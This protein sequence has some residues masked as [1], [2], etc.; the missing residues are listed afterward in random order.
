MITPI[1]LTKKLEK[2]LSK[3]ITITTPLLGNNFGKWNMTIFYIA[4]KKWLLFTHSETMFSIVLPN[5][6][7]S[8]LKNIDSLFFNSF[9]EQLIFEKIDI[10]YAILKELIGNINFHPTDNDKRTIGVQNSILETIKQ[11]KFRYSNF[12]DI[13]ANELC[14]RLN[15]A[16]Y[17]FLKWEFPLEKMS[18]KLKFIKK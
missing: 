4:K 3:Q 18:D 17:S 15:H 5:I 14:S 11:F 16:P 6:K 2:L 12:K 9:H 10:D 13:S 7:L 8:D 1:F